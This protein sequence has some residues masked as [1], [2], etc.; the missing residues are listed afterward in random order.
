MSFKPGSLSQ[1]DVLCIAH[2]LGSSWKMVGRVLMVPE[3]VLD[4]IQEDETKVSE[5]CYRKCNCVV[6]VVIVGA[7]RFLQDGR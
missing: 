1:D 5:Q 3:D 7:K 6:C 4:L 2:E